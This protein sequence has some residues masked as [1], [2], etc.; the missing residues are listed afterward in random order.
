LSQSETALKLAHQE[1]DWQRSGDLLKAVLGQAPERTEKGVKVFDYGSED[2]VEI[3]VDPRLTLQQ[4]TEKFFQNAKR[5]A[6][7]I[8]EAQNRI[9]NGKEA[10]QKIEK[11]L[12][13]ILTSGD[14][15]ALRHLEVLAGLEKGRETPGDRS[16]KKGIGG[17]Q[18]IGVAGGKT[19]MTPQGWLIRV[20][21]NRDENREL[22]QIARG[23]DV[24][25]HIRGRPGAHVVIQVPA[26]KSV[27]LETLLDGALLAIHYSGGNHWGKTEVDYTFRKFVKRI[28]DSTEVSYTQNK[29]LWVTPDPKRL[30]KLQEN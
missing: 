9:Q 24:W 8:E 23:N 26:G 6:R 27:P 28:K 25:M 2:W 30:Q 1:G 12:A 4:Q 3:L 7:R 19:F 21:R 17:G 15:A 5:K 29:T 22:F 20:G 16:A 11:N 18:G 10:I 13:L 14:W